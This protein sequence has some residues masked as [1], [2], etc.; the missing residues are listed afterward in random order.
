VPR[1]DLA[2]LLFGRTPGVCNRD[3]RGYNA[4]DLQEVD[5]GGF[6]PARGRVAARAIGETLVLREGVFDGW[7][8]RCAPASIPSAPTS[9]KHCEPSTGK[10]T[11]Y[12]GN[13]SEVTTDSSRVVH[14]NLG[15]SLM[16]MATELLSALAGFFKRF[17]Y[18]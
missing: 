9:S 13:I 18:D 14:W 15:Q 10:P 12:G 5:D 7:R 8:A 17:C 16:V 2:G 4:G 3:A 1:A 11:G 6:V